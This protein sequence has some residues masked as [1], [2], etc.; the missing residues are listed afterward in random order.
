MQTFSLVDPVDKKF[1]CKEK[2]ASLIH[3][4]YYFDTFHF[5]SDGSILGSYKDNRSGGLVQNQLDREE[6][7]VLPR[8]NTTAGEVDIFICDPVTECEVGI[9]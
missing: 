2:N 1:Y 8:T 3:I 7:C 4:E 5:S 6:F 9:V